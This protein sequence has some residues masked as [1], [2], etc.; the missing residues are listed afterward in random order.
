MP[1]VA[2]FG[3]QVQLDFFFPTDLTGYTHLLL[4]MLDVATLLHM[5]RRCS[6]RNAEHVWRVFSEAWQ[7]PFGLPRDIVCDMDGAFRGFSERRRAS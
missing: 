1:R 7:I 6:S 5:V 2:Q 3:D 4:G